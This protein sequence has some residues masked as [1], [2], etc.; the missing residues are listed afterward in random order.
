VALEAIRACLAKLSPSQLELVHGRYRDGHSAEELAQQLGKTGANV[1][2]MLG[3][4]RSQIR[5]CV[6]RHLATEA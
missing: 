1:R 2:Q 3:R 4:I 5:A 6:E